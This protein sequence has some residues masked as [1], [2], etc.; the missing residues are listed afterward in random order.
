VLG[1]GDVLLQFIQLFFEFLDFSGFN[2]RAP[3]PGP[4]LN[5]FHPVVHDDHGF[6]ENLHV[7]VQIVE[8]LDHQVQF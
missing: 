7:L 8:L 1:F 5:A 3:G 4:G 2:G 6:A